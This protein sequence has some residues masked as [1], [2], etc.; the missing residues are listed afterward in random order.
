MRK[1]RSPR[2]VVVRNHAERLTLPM[3]PVAQARSTAMGKLCVGVFEET[4][5]ATLCVE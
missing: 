4:R 5:P 2:S 3:G 1:K